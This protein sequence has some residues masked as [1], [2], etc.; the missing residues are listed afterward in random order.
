[1]IPIE[2]HELYETVENRAKDERALHH[3]GCKE[4]CCRRVSVC[5]EKT[6][7]QQRES[8][9]AG[10]CGVLLLRVVFAAAT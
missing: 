7:H 9:K 10:Q 1:M 5:W 2:T 8:Y 3:R 6:W 4:T